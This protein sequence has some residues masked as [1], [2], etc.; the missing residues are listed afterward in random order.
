MCLKSIQLI[1]CEA[2]QQLPVMPNKDSQFYT[3]IHCFLFFSGILL[4]N[5]QP[6]SDHLSDAKDT[7]SMGDPGS[8]KIWK[9]WISLLALN[10]ALSLVGLL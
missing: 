7:C 10:N 4:Q 9:L 8:A 6:G 3:S 2:L 1:L 5:K